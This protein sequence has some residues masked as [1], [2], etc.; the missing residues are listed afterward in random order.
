MSARV[1]SESESMT[2]AFMALSPVIMTVVTVAPVYIHS[3]ESA[4]FFS[5]F[6]SEVS[7]YF[8]SHSSQMICDLKV[9]VHS[10]SST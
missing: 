8:F 10:R 9:L 5:Y 6:Q 7:P 3:Q 2:T 1:S 4:W